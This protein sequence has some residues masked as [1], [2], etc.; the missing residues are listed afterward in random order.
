[1]RYGFNMH[2]AERELLE[3][4]RQLDRTVKQM[5]AANPKP[6]LLPLFARIET[7][8]ANLPPGTDP[9]LAHFIQRKS[10]EKALALM[11]ERAGTGA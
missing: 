7:A 5:A 1:M 6:S 8:A 4:L 10:Y 11:E 9:Q 3:A 2:D